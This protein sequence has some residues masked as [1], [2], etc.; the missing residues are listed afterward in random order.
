[1]FNEIKI[2]VNQVKDI[3][4]TLKIQE[5]FPGSK[6]DRIR[7][8]LREYLEQKIVNHARTLKPLNKPEQWDI[9]EPKPAKNNLRAGTTAYNRAVVL[10][11]QAGI[12]VSEDMKM[13]W[14]NLSIDDFVVVGRLTMN[15]I[16]EFNARY[17][18][19]PIIG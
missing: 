18:R 9:V 8:E 2:D 14:N 10:D 1:M 11:H 4:D 13:V 5:I 19:Y 3:I 7:I 17:G 6:E 12:F 15:K 16:M